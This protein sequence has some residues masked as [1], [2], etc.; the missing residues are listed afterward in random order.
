MAT[1]RRKQIVQAGYDAIAERYLDWGHGIEGD[2][3]HRLLDELMHMLP[4]EGRV[5]DL[6]CGPGV[7]STKLLAERFQVV[8][9]DISETQLQL[10][11]ENV[12]NA[13]FVLADITEVGFPAESF[14]GVTAF[15]SIL[16]VPREQHAE[17]IRKI[18]RWLRPGGCFLGCLGVSGEE[19]EV[20][21]LGVPMYFSSYDPDTSRELFRDAG[22]ELVYDEVIAMREPEQE[23]SFFWVLA[24]KPKPPE[25]RRR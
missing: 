25:T 10:A 1:D 20:D 19:E 16:H 17:L 2:P 21:W 7:P 15:Y 22:L 4:P 3:R 18:A 9:V 13:S 14:V 12:P 8:G 11:S 5:L 24:E 23:A 6:G